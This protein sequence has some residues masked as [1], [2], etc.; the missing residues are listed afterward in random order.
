M[1]RPV[2]FIKQLAAAEKAM[3]DVFSNTNVLRA[4]T[5]SAMVS[6]KESAEQYIAALDEDEGAGVKDEC[7][8]NQRE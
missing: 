1:K 7:E 2:P 8:L 5:R 6:L 4:T 3:A